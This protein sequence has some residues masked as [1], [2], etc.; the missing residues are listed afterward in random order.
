[1]PRSRLAGARAPRGG[2][3]RP[4]GD[5]GQARTAGGRGGRRRPGLV[6]SCAGAPPTTSCCAGG[7]GV[8]RGPV[9]AASGP[10]IWGLTTVWI[11]CG[12]RPAPGA[13]D[14]VVWV[15]DD[16]PAAPYDGRLSCATT[17]SGSS[18]TCASSIR[19][20]SRPSTDWRDEVCITCS[21]EG[22]VAEVVQGRRP[23]PWCGPTRVPTPS[24][25]CWSARSSRGPGAGPRRHGHRTRRRGRPSVDAGGPDV[26]ERHRL[27]VSRSSRATST[28]PAPCSSTWRRRRRPR[29][30]PA[31]SLREATFARL[32]DR[33]RR[34]RRAMADRFAAGGR[35]FTFGNGGSATDAARWRRCSAA[36]P[37][38]ARYRRGRLAD[39]AAVLTALANDVGFE[40]VFSRQLIAHAGPGDIAVGI[41]TSGN[42][43]NLLRA[44][45]EARRARPAHARV[46]RLRRRRDGRGAAC[47]THC[48]VVES[49]SVHRIQEVQAALAFAP[50]VGGPG[51]PR[52]R[53]DRCSDDADADGPT[54]AKPRSST[55]S[56]PS[57]AVGRASRDDVVTLAHGAGG[58]ASAALVDAVFLDAFARRRPR[59][60]S[61]TRPSCRSP[62]GRADSRSA[63]TRSSC[64]RCASPAARSATSRCTAPSTTWRCRARARAWL[65]AAFVLEEGFPIAELRGIAADMADAAAGPPG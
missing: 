40:L 2:R 42:S 38:V 57:G 58:K 1:M 60:R 9:R 62:G 46:R 54:T 37:S 13:A 32:A 59:R 28:T 33:A 22:S 41:S 64:N 20:C 61:P 7:P 65:S 63:P 24:T 12:S 5:H 51:V 17:C 29:S 50:V 3:V 11:G 52:R 16:G 6:P 8:D 53:S 47:S 26:A 44:F 43:R 45:A 55:A 4:P 18:P 27:P 35:L 15:D 30:P 49:D 10:G 23:T 21:D 34:D 14:H 25:R 48:L 56:T 19:A 36:R 39:D 31:T